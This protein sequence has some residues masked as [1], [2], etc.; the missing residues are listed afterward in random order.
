MDNKVS[1]KKI[2]LST[3]KQ[4][5]ASVV[6]THKTQEKE[7]EIYRDVFNNL[8]II[9]IVLIAITSTGIIYYFIDNNRIVGIIACIISFCALCITLFKKF[10]DPLRLFN[11]H[12][13]AANLLLGFRDK[14]LILISEICI[15]DNLDEIS[16][17]LKKI[18]DDLH[19]L[20]CDI[21]STGHKALKMAEKSLKNGEYT[22]SE[23]EI[24]RFLPPYLRSLED[25]IS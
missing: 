25:D 4:I 16:K 3:I 15:G 5:Y 19:I 20:Y 11:E 14:L 1:N 17:K 8:E 22:F 24:N 10:F 6:W 23:E 13:N 2:M 18:N 12:K 9:N 21:P 7:A